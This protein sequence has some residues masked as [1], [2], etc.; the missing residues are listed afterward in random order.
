M[1]KILLSFFALSVLFGDKAS[2]LEVINAVAAYR[3]NITGAGI[4]IGVID[5]AANSEH[6]FLIDKNGKSKV[7]DQLFSSNNTLENIDFS[8]NTHGT[9]VTS[10]IIGNQNSPAQGVAY[11]ANTYNVQL[12]LGSSQMPE[13]YD[14]FV[15]NKVVA[16]NNSW[17]GQIYPFAYLVSGFVYQKAFDL[18]NTTPSDWIESMKI[19]SPIVADDLIRLS[20]DN[21]ALVVFS[22][23]NDGI[24]GGKR[25]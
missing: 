11:D 1:K 14:Y 20:R 19:A 10:I 4:N 24:C 5:Q 2:D 16:I 13:I 8:S 17:G 18:E 3:Q 22:V 25:L 9:F 6:V 12:E 21:K 23:E 7:K 15:K